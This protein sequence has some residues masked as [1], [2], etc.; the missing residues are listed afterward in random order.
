MAYNSFDRGTK[1]DSAGSMAKNGD[2]ANDGRKRVLVVGA[3]AA[4]YVPVELL[5]Y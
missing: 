5:E 1:R 4:G 2:T 3:G